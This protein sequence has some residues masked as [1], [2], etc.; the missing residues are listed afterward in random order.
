MTSDVIVVGAGVAG[1]AAARALAEAGLD[2]CVLEARNRV[3][4]RILTEQVP[5]FALPLEL[6]AEFVHGYADE[7]WDLVR[8]AG[9]P[10]VAVGERHD[11]ARDGG[12][13]PGADIQGPLAELAARAAALEM[14]QPVAALLRNMA[15][16]PDQA[17]IL[18]RYVEGFHAADPARASARALGTV[19]S[20]QGSGS[21]IGF[22]LLGGGYGAVVDELRAGVP[23]DAVTF[24][25]AVTHIA[26]TRGSVTVQS[27]RSSRSAGAAVVTVPAP[28]L[29]SRTGPTFDPPLP[30]KQSALTQIGA[31]P[32]LRVLL[33]FRTSWWEEL[34]GAHRTSDPVGFIHIPNA[35][36]P[37]WWTP[38]PIRA[39]LLVGWAGGPSAARFAGQPDDVLVRAGLGTLAAAFELSESRLRD[40]LLDARTHDWSSDPWSLGAYSYLLAGGEGAQ[41]RLAAPVAQTLF[42]AGEATHPGGENA[43]VHGAIETGV[44]A[45]REVIA[46][47]G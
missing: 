4:G 17:A 42:F 24:G 18:T 22:R 5:G 3:G 23:G 41:S 28:V 32:A 20:G 10:I 39:P 35:P 30:E 6:G 40:L 14:D 46:A 38:A 27:G 33:R 45:A 2:V 44:R 8:N 21:N 25:A 19:E 16:P 13:S 15:L 26:W 7:I 12:L 31:G 37:T 43:S 34:P 36:L 11:L 47:L 9:L 29:A 1:L